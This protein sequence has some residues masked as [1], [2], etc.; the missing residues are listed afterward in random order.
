MPI[1]TVPRSMQVPGMKPYMSTID[2]ALLKPLTLSNSYSE[3]KP[4]FGVEIYD[5]EENRRTTEYSSDSKKNKKSSSKKNLLQKNTITAT[6]HQSI[7]LSMEHVSPLL[8]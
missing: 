5:K 7:N 1:S 2:A 4:N 3:Y 6:S 8:K